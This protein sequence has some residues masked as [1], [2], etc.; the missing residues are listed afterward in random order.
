MSNILIDSCFWYALFDAS[1]TH[2]SKA[3]K[4]AEYLDFG[5]III[6]FPILYETLNTRFVKRK[7]WISIF[8]EYL[9]RETTVIVFDDKYRGK[10]LETTM[11]DS[12]L[13]TRPMS[14]VDMTIRLMLDDVN[15]NISTLITFNVGDF[16][17]VCSSKR[18]ELI[19]EG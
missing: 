10:A 5:K 14:L 3:Q 12:Q 8:N 18:I 17:D 16:I 6:P 7:H 1:D 9:T 15:L 11:I 4:L 13:G 2:H 19:S